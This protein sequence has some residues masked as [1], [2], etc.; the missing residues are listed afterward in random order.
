MGCKVY[1]SAGLQFC[2][3]SYQAILAKYDFLSQS[4]LTDFQAFLPP[5]KQQDF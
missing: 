2:I 4:T 3:I 5:E 1:S